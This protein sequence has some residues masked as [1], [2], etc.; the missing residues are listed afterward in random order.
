MLIGKEEELYSGG[1]LRGRLEAV[2]SSGLDD[3]QEEI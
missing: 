1:W 3:L 2:T